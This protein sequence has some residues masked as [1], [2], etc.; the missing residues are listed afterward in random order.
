MT[1][2][3]IDAV[4][5]WQDDELPTDAELG[6]DPGAAVDGYLPD[7]AV[8]DPA[9]QRHPSTHD[10]ANQ[11]SHLNQFVRGV[12]T[13]QREVE[14]AA[15]RKRGIDAIHALADFF[16]AYPEVPLPTTVSATSYVEDVLQL[17]R[18]AEQLQA[19]IYGP[20]RAPQLCHQASAD[21]NPVWAYALVAVHAKDRPL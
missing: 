13:A 14:A 2:H 8:T 5:V 20:D 11:A 15:Q 21:R 10:A 19:K 17:E 1:T 12:R 3:P 9:Q 7:V 6:I 4:G 16:A 18:L